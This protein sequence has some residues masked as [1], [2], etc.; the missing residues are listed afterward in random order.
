MQ[1]ALGL[2]DAIAVDKHADDADP[3]GI[4]EDRDRQGGK[5]Q[6]DLVPCWPLVEDAE[7]EAEAH[8]RKEITEPAAGLGHLELVH[9]EINDVAVE[10]HRHSEQGNDPHAD[11]RGDELKLD[12]Q[13]PV[14]EV[15]QRQHEQKISHRYQQP[16]ATP[17][18]GRRHHQ[19]SDADDEAVG[20]HIRN[21]GE[22]AQQTD[23]QSEPDRG[24]A[25]C[26]PNADG[27]FVA[28]VAEPGQKQVQR[29]QRNQV[30]VAVFR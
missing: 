7:Q 25:H 1:K 22:I 19:P 5:E 15:R 29:D 28:L 3:E 6:H 10:I 26:R 8:Q 21:V 13:R 17:S 30:A 16:E 9:A 11:L 4:H 2:R 12:R 23:D 27:V 24:H 18:A 20:R 14:N